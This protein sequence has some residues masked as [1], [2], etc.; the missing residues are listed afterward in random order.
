MK[1]HETYD[2]YYDEDA[3]FLEVSFEESAES[4][5]TEEPEEGV[6]VTRDGDTN[7]V[8]NVG[9]LSFKKRPEVLKK[10]LLSLGKRLP[11]EISVPSK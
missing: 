7:R 4:G 6:F 10:I 5:T 8:A 1:E 9:I 3:D 11:L 2:W